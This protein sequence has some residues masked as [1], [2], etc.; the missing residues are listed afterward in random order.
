MQIDV[1][2]KIKK[3]IKSI[4]PYTKKIIGEY[5]SFSDQ[6]IDQLIAEQQESFQRWRLFSFAKR[7]KPV[8]K[9]AGLLKKH[10]NE[11]AS[12]VT[13]EM[14]KPISESV[15]EIRKC[16]W[17]CEYYGNE[18]EKYLAPELVHT[19]AQE[20]VI[21]YEP[22][23]II[24]GIMPWNFPFWQVF[25]FAIPTLLAGNAVLLKHAPNVSGCS[26]AIEKLLLEAGFPQSLFSVV[27]LEAER[28]EMIIKHPDIH[29]VTITGSANAGAA[30]AS[31]AGKYLKK[32]VMELGGSDPL[33]AFADAGLAACCEAATSSRMINAG[34]VCI[35]AKRFL[36]E[37]SIFEEF[38]QHQKTA[39][40]ALLIG[41]PLDSTTQI[42][43]MARPDL[44]D[45][46]DQ[47]VK[48]SV[49]MG[50]TVVTG[51]EKWKKN[52]ACYVPTLLTNVSFDM[53]V[54]REETFGPVAVVIPFDTADEAIK[55]ANDTAYG[56][57][58]SV[59][60]S[61]PA[62]AKYVASRLDVG[63]V[64]V[65]SITKS[66]PRLPFGGTKK[67][68]YGRELAHFG[69]IEFTNIKTTWIQ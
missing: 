61:D 50:A 55:I 63:A 14:G 45:Q 53:P 32:S 24:F 4:N 1:V 59:W 39:L 31:L 29:G 51:G 49:K 65:N 11:L 58:A 30:V 36:V 38:V 20:S 37:R 5:E 66:D 26:L 2:N 12:L 10:E 42:G 21:S 8:I 16:V 25:R 35:A 33:I 46:L 22:K 54:F 67:S 47:Q 19:E 18:G 62:K 56:L 40:V 27:I 69:M 60:T 64:F 3:M 41:D 17:L 57:G 28:S 43:P 68:G 44:L 13:S 52:S 34:Q 6:K 15:A 9:L 48:E 23:G 7:S